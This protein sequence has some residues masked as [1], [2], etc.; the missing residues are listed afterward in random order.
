MTTAACGLA[1]VT[2]CYFGITMTLHEIESAIAGLTPIELSKFR[3]WFVE[4]DAEAWDRQFDDNVRAG[5]LDALAEEAL[6]DLRDGRT[7]EQ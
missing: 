1:P 5:R 3:T 6:Q 7:T 2:A 4:F